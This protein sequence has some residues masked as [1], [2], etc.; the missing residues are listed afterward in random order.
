L[1]LRDIRKI[2]RPEIYHGRVNMKGYFEGWY[3]KFADKNAQNLGALIPGV[4]FDKAGSHPHCFI[5]FLDDAG[6]LSHYFSYDI[7]QF[8]YS[9]DNPEIKIGDS[10]FSPDRIE[11][12]IKDNSN[13]ISGAL[14]FTGITPWP[15]KLFSPGAMGP[16]A[17]VPLMECYHGV[18][19][20]DHLIE[21]QLDLNGKLIDFSGGRGYTEKDWGRSFPSYHVWIQ[22]NHFESP[23][24]SLMVSIANIPWL[25]KA[26]DGFLAGLWHNG[27]LYKFTTYS[28]ARI[29]LFRFDQEKLTVCFQSKR[30]R[31]EIEV[32]YKRGPELRTPVAGDMQGR[33]SESLSAETR[34]RLIGLVRGLEKLIFE[35]TG[36][37]TGLEIE[38]RLPARLRQ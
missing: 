25:G 36:R 8:S 1:F 32:V 30:H 2:W 3:Y 5:Q 4:S 31:L 24:T 21:G 18:L 16:Y 38:G 27:Q 34:V 22:T 29:T 12:N 26:F 15:V 10:F 11:V 13:S 6:I 23:G 28:G 35:G 7:N 37:H 17:F 19:S 33:L 14:S 9:R 20:F